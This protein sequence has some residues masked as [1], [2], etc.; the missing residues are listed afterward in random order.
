MISSLTN[1]L[2]KVRKIELILSRANV[3]LLSR[4]LYL[5]R[6]LVK[7]RDTRIIGEIECCLNLITLT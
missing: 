3:K 7:K 1:M 2:K 5:S 4:S 6:E